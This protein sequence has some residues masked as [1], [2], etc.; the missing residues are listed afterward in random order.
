MSFWL[1]FAITIAIVTLPGLVEHLTH[2]KQGELSGFDFIPLGL[3]IFGILLLN[4]GR[5][6]G[7]QEEAFLLGFLQTTLQARLEDSRFFNPQRV[8]ENK[9]L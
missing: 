3:V 9:P 1:T 4:F 8:T 7:K 2:P 5:R 6:I